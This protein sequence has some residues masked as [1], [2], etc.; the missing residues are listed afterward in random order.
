[1]LPEP[2]AQTRRG[3]GG[4]SRSAGD[5]PEEQQPAR[6]SHPRCRGGNIP[7]QKGQEDEEEEEIQS[8][9]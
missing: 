7:R 3:V 8:L 9:R 2:P 5:R 6:G 4:S 1:M